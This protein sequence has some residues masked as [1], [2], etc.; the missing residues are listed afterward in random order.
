MALHV[1]RLCD[2]IRVMYP[3][4]CYDTR[5]HTCADFV[6]TRQPMRH[7]TARDYTWPERI[8]IYTI[9][10]SNSNSK[11]RTINF[12]FVRKY[13]F[14]IIVSL[15]Y[16]CF[17]FFFFFHISAVDLICYVVMWIKGLVLL[18]RSLY[19]RFH[20]IKAWLSAGLYSK[21]GSWTCVA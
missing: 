3:F 20:T 16:N 6:T 8:K 19:S 21:H 2:V 10:I 9:I 11:F 15:F 14:N 12:I 4:A 7:G 13:N 1:Y 18:F 5:H 17:Q